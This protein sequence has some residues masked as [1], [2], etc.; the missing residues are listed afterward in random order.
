MPGPPEGWPKC[1]RL[2][3][4]PGEPRTLSLKRKELQLAQPARAA[5][6]VC[7]VITFLNMFKV[8][9]NLLQSFLLCTVRRLF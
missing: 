2:V 1:A 5:D 3:R 9:F 7:K 6:G 8:I 4:N